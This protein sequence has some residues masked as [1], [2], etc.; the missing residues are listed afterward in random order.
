MKVAK[1]FAK[2]ERYFGMEKN[3]YVIKIKAKKGTKGIAINGKE[4]GKYEGQKEWL[5]NHGQKYITKNIDHKNRI[6]EIELI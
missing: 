5:L 1:N 4:L 2:T 3:P 6:I